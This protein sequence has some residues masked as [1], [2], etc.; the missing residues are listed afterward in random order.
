MSAPQQSKSLEA[1]EAGRKLMV[2]GFYSEA[3]EPLQASLEV[4]IHFKTLELIGECHLKMGK[5]T[6]R[7][8]PAR[9]GL[10][11]ESGSTGV[12]FARARIV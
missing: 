5:P 8:H 9:G 1:Y 11:V 2:E 6:C 3:L 4:C 7:H 12:I 10:G